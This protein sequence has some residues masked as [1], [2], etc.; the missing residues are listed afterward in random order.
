L[1]RCSLQPKT[2]QDKLYFS[3][4]IKYRIDQVNCLEK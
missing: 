4:S 1:K 3:I 2:G